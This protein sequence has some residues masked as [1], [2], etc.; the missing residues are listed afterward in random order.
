MTPIYW[1]LQHLADVPAGDEWLSP[2]ERAVRGRLWAPKRVRDWRLGRWAAKRAVLRAGGP[3]SADLHL[4]AYAAISVLST[5]AGCPRV[6]EDGSESAWALSLSHS[7]EHGLCVLARRPAAVGCDIETIG[8]RGEEF[9]VEWF[10][11][12]ERTIVDSAADAGERSRLVTTVWSAKESALKALGVG[13]RMDT[14]DVDVGLILPSLDDARGD[15]EALEGSKG[16]LRTGDWSPFVVTSI[17]GSFH[18]WS[19]TY[20]DQVLTMVADPPPAAPIAL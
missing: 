16:G 10:T 6:L 19:R 8:R 17:R 9:V 1:I 3:A 15:P 5:D 20:G 4:G 12:S 7:G 14:R 2:A 11:D 18:G 13:L